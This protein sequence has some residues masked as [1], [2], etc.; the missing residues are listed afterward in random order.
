[1]EL[2]AQYIGQVK[3][4]QQFEESN[5][6][7]KAT[8]QSFAILSSGMY[9][10]KI[11]AIVRELSTNA[12]DSHVQA[13]KA[14]VPFDIYFPNQY[15]PVFKIRD[16]GISIPHEDMQEVYCSFFGSTKTNTNTLNGAFGLGSKAFFSYV[17]SANITTYIDGV[18]RMYVAMLSE[19]GLPTLNFLGECE[20]SEPNGLEIQLPVDSGDFYAFQTEASILQ[21]FPTKPQ[22]HGIRGFSWDQ[23]EETYHSSIKG[24]GWRINKESNRHSAVMGYIAYPIDASELTEIAAQVLYDWGYSGSLEISFEIGEFAITP[25]REQISYTEKT[26]QV[27]SEKVIR[28]RGE[29]AALIQAEVDKQSSYIDACKLYI[30]EKNRFISDILSKSYWQDRK[31]GAYFVLKNVQ[32]KFTEYSATKNTKGSFSVNRDGDKITRIKIRDFYTSSI[33]FYYADMGNKSAN[34]LRNYLRQEARDSGSPKYAIL[35]SPPKKYKDHSNLGVIGFP[36]EKI[37][38]VSEIVDKV[39][40]IEKEPRVNL[41]TSI[42]QLQ[43]ISYGRYQY[44]FW[45]KVHDLDIEEGGLW[46]PINGHDLWE[47]EGFTL[48]SISFTFKLLRSENPDITVYGVRKRMHKKFEEHPK[49]TRF[50]KQA[51][52]ALEKFIEY[53]KLTQAINYSLVSKLSEYPVR[54]NLSKYVSMFKYAKVSP[55]FKELHNKILALDLD[56]D[57]NALYYGRE[58]RE[59]LEKLASIDSKLADTIKERLDISFYKLDFNKLPSLLNDLEKRYPL[60]SYVLNSYEIYDSTINHMANYIKNAE[61]TL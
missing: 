57:E 45:N 17:H 32:E 1:M 6:T 14:D 52:L 23:Y 48:S 46:I 50:D 29:L 42:L 8:A 44:Q 49:W 53:D 40:K 58:Y 3:K 11:R 43:S 30:D 5:F 54:Y 12:Y 37:K 59:K 26:K 2:E 9:S 56:V 7:I 15:V 36:I 19:Q 20:T 24:D 51:F 22:V 25:S 16:Y 60:I 27:I 4:S 47:V 41:S 34:I 39:K 35:I 13:G 31:L 18:Q 10:N 38:L 33:E 61:D 21:H 55:E 28:I